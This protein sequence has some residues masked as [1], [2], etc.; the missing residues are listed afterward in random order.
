MHMIFNM[1]G[2]T[3]PSN[4]LRRSLVILCLLFMQQLAA[5]PVI[6]SFSPASGP[7][8][9]VVTITGENFDVTPVNNNV[10]F[11][12]LRATVSSATT[13]RLEVIV[14]AGTTYK[15]IS[16]TTAGL[17]GYSSLPFLVTVQG[18]D[19]LNADSFAPK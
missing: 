13:S 4:L 6:K 12:G 16:V 17:T 18:G 11:G 15:P 1:T 7:I 19:I 8:G 2:F 10:Y 5:Q 9:A 14:P 3:N